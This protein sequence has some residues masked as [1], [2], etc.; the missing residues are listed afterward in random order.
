MRGIVEDAEEW[1]KTGPLR[2]SWRCRTTRWPPP[3]ASRRRR[4]CPPPPCPPCHWPAGRL[5]FPA[6]YPDQGSQQAGRGPYR[7][8]IPL[9]QLK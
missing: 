3:T 7:I 9:L 4:R 8:A 1:E 6:G 2:L 5:R